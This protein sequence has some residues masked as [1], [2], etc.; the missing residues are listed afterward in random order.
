MQRIIDERNWRT[1][2]EDS[3]RASQARRNNRRR[4]IP[5]TIAVLFWAAVVVAVVAGLCILMIEG[6]R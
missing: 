4:R 6:G 2:C 5:A 3:L 1:A